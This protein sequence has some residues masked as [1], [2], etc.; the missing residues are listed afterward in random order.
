[1][2]AGIRWESF[3]V[4]NGPTGH[5]DASLPRE[6]AMEARRRGV[7]CP[8]SCF[9]RN[10][11]ETPPVPFEPGRCR[12]KGRNGEADACASRRASVAA[13]SQNVARSLEDAT[14]ATSHESHLTHVRRLQSPRTGS[15][16]NGRAPN[17][18][19][20]GA[21]TL[22]V[23]M[24]I[25]WM[26]P[27]SLRTAPGIL[28]MEAEALWPRG[29]SRN[30]SVGSVVVARSACATPSSFARDPALAGRLNHSSA[31]PSLPFQR[32]RSG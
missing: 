4:I 9:P 26:G 31:L 15:P 18:C 20:N 25:L 28:W 8:G 30:D 7:G 13:A 14:R 24:E 2:S 27:G 16:I 17:A 11:G 19:G 1:M 21:Q 23:T 6:G 12:W 10:T 32:N 3:R 29:L 5:G 22:P